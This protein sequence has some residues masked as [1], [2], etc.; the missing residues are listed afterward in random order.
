MAQGV[1]VRDR[2]FLPVVSTG[3][4]FFRHTIQRN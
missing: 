2:L 4:V 1:S 3:P